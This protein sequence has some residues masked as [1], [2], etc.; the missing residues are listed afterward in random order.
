MRIFYAR[1]SALWNASDLRGKKMRPDC[2]FS[3]VP[4][5]P[6]LAENTRNDQGAQ[7]G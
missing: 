2:S 7:M 1:H 5:L 6:W 3:G 4:R